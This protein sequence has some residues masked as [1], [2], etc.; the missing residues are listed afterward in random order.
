MA[1]TYRVGV[2]AMV[3]DHVWGEIRRWKALPNVEL[4]A[5]G[6]VNQELRDKAQT[7]F[8]I[9]RAYNSWEEM[10][11]N[12]EL[13]IVQAASENSVSADIVDACSARGVNVISEKPMSATLAQ[14]NRMVAAAN[15]AGIT[16]LINWPSAW[17]PAIQEMERR[18]LAG[19]I[20]EVR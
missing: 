13:D 12:E 14:A 19:D 3:H 4:V 11:E 8:G 20:G 18:I 9:P 2:A 7:E 16:L 15:D 6:D 1:K 5:A 10:L 17:N